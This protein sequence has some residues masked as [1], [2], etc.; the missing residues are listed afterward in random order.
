MPTI[1]DVSRRA[2]V[3]PTTVSR[4][5]NQKGYISE[6]TYAKVRQ[7][8]EDLNYVPNQIARSLFKQRS[9]YICVLVPDS[10]NPFWAQIVRSIEIKAYDEG[11]KLFLCNTNDDANRERDYIQMM[12]QNMVDGVILGTHMLE[13]EE[14]R[15][16]TL[17]VVA[18]DLFLGDHIPTVCSDHQK[19]GQLAAG[20][21]IRSQSKYVLN[22]RAVIG[23]H[24]P[25]MMRHT[26]VEEILSQQGI[27]VINYDLDFRA[28]MSDYPRIIQELFQ[29]YPEID[30]IYSQDILVVNAMKYALEKGMRI[31]QDFKAVSYDGTFIT[32]LCYPTLTC[33]EQ[34][35]DALA[36]T[37]V[38]IL[39]R[40]INGEEVHGNIVL[41]G[42]R[43]RKGKTTL[44]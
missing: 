1:D 21:L 26:I 41:P 25:S 6:A 5:L 38:D 10:S 9:W 17:P 4:V 36:S 35:I 22:V 7:A 12:R 29:R 43:L 31:P 16:L 2:G 33:V 24:T 42:I 13:M 15:N 40:K 34:P 18:L 37:L 8:I 20:E 32:E 27:R 14:Y 19:G 11:Y 23:K 30:S 28:G 3:S 44:L 39:V